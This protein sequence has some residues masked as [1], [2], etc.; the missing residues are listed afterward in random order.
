[1]NRALRDPRERILVQPG[2]VLILQEMSGEAV[3]RYFSEVFNNTIFW[4]FIDRGDVS[5]V[6]TLS[7]P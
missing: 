3:A 5:G 7:T 2:D 6:A 1:L 4:R